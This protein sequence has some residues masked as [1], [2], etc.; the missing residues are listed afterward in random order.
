MRL[1]VRILRWLNPQL[2]D[3]R[4]QFRRELHYSEANTEHLQRLLKKVING[5]HHE[6]VQGVSLPVSRD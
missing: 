3:E 1:A 5:H 2:E 4:M 6:D